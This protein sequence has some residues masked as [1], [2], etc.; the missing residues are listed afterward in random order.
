MN[1]MINLDEYVGKAIHCPTEELA[2]EFLNLAHEQGFRWRV[3]DS[4]IE[5]N[6]WDK[7]KENTCYI[8]LKNKIVNFGRIAYFETYAYEIFEFEGGERKLWRLL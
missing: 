1:K 4:L 8:L 2:N 5:N 3:G 6:Y 7:F